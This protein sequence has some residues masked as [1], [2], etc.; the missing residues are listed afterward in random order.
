MGKI[1]TYLTS[2]V[3]YIYSKKIKKIKRNK[4]VTLSKVSKETK[5]KKLL[6]LSLIFVI[7][8]SLNNFVYAAHLGRIKVDGAIGCLDKK[9]YETS[10][11]CIM[12]GDSY[13]IANL[14]VQNKCTL[15][16]EGDIV[17]IETL[18][19]AGGMIEI[20]KKN[21]NTLWKISSSFV[22]PIK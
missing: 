9:S 22:E 21:S 15:F 3:M 6:I 18:S 13:C 17:Y 8:F 20:R 1:E 10:L 19:L 4:V 2:G 7:S 11:H 14:V 12:D 16:R 5:M